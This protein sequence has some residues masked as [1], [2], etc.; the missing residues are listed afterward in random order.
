MT[1]GP[2]PGQPPGQPNYGQQPQGGYGPPP[3]GQPGQYGPPPGQYGPPPGQY[4]PPPGQYGARKP[5]F[6]FSAVNPYDWG[7]FAAGL[8]AFIFSFLSFYT[9]TVSASFGGQSISRSAHENA[10]HGFFGWFAVLLAL[11]AAA[12][13][14]VDVFVPQFK[15]PVPS[16]LVALG[17]F[18]LALLC[19]IIA[20]FVTP[21]KASS[22]AIP[23]GVN[24]DY[25][26]GFG[27]WIVLIAI[28]AGTALSAMR[29]QQTGGNLASLFGG[30]SKPKS[31]PAYAPPPQQ[32]GPP[33]QYGAPPSYPQQPQQ[34]PQQPPYQPPPQQQ[35][36][37][38]P[39]YQPPPQQQP[40][41]QPPPPAQPGY[42]PPPSGYQPPQEQ[43]PPQGEQPPQQ[44]PSGEGQQQ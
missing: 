27:F 4:G 26:R 29:Y 33:P 14:A 28:V 35:P 36:Y 2:P 22:G 37:Q 15:L 31:Q 1:Y 20:A 42:Q 5:G 9:G 12:L 7:I 25:G 34:A 16:R 40:S 8:V 30:L 10:W 6:D 17:G 32:Y 21:G 24:V 23:E 41:Y 13:V 39:A 43:Q 19:V 38:P 18:G 44:P 3:Q 11:A